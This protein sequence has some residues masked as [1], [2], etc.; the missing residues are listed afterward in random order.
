MGQGPGF[1][2]FDFSL[3][4]EIPFAEHRLVQLRGEFFNAL[5]RPN[6]TI[7]NGSRGSAPFGQISSTINPGRFIQIGL[8][9]VY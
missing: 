4:K 9:V 2:D 7:P 1:V 8:R 3:L 5:N 6:F